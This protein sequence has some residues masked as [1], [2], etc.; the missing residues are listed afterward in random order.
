MVE[1]F[2]AFYGDQAGV[3]EVALSTAALD[4]MQK[5]DWPGNIRELEH[6]IERAINQWN[7]NLLEVRHFEWLAK[8]IKDKGQTN[9]G[10]GIKEAKAE[11][12]KEVIQNALQTAR[13]N[14]TKAAELLNIARPLLYQK[15]RRL[16]IE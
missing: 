3:G 14:K 12:E 8:K 15:M 1:K 11:S 4:L 13:G 6:A 5:Y 2:A 9:A 7:S 16:G 10:Q